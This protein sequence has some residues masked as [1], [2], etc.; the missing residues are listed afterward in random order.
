MTQCW[1]ALQA[2]CRPQLHVPSA[3]HVSLVSVAQERQ[4]APP[5]PQ[6]HKPPSNGHGPGAAARQLEPEQHPAQVALVQL[7]QRPSTQVCAPQFW[8]VKPFFPH[9]SFVVPGWTQVSPSAEQQ[10]E[11][12]DESQTQLPPTHF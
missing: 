12:V 2:G 11:Q 5:A 4:T 1:P 8:Q 6:G 9:A 7:L 10:P 3:L